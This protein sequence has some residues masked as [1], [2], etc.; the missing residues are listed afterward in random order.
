MPRLGLPL[1]GPLFLSLLL[2]LPEEGFVRVHVGRGHV[3]QRHIACLLRQVENLETAEG[4]D[5]ILVPGEIE[6]RNEERN[7]KRGIP[8]GPG[9][10]RDLNSL[11][12]DFG[13]A[14]RLE[15]HLT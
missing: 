8:V 1:T 2:L 12:D 3:D 4:V 9:V 6:A 14:M 15:D 13:L 10:L 11:R 7:R 5:E